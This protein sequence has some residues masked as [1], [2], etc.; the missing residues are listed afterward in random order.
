M[1]RLGWMRQNRKQEQEQKVHIL[2]YI[3][4]LNE[5]CENKE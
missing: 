2:G 4:R 1:K 3:D 5:E